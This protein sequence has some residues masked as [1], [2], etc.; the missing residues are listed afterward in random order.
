VDVDRLE[1]ASVSTRFSGSSELMIGTR[2]VTITDRPWVLSRLVAQD[3]ARRKEERTNGAFKQQDVPNDKTTN[4]FRPQSSLTSQATR[5]IRLSSNRLILV[6][7]EP[8]VGFAGNNGTRSRG[9]GQHLPSAF[10][11]IES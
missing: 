1:T 4:P 2:Y 3:V 11:G 10:D 6:K 7:E 9:T 5:P 8:N